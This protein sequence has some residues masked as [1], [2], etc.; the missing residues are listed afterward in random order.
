MTSGCSVKLIASSISEDTGIRLDTLQVRYWRP[1]HGEVMTHRVFSRNASSS[2]AIPAA[3]IWAREEVYVPRFRKNKPGMQPGAFLSESEQAEAAAIWIE[4]ARI[5]QD[6][7]GRLADKNGLN[8]HKQWVNRP[9]EWYSYIDVLITSTEWSNF[10]GLRIHPDAQDEIRELAT[11]MKRV[12]DAATPQVLKHGQWHL[13]YITAQDFEETARLV[14]SR[15]MPDA[16]CEVLAQLA[17]TRL[18]VSPRN[19]LLLAMSAARSCRISF[20]KHDGA[21]PTIENDAT[22]YLQLAGSEPLHASPL[23]HQGRPL[24]ATEDERLSGN[25]VGFAQF[26]K[27]LPNERL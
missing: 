14:K 3:S 21:R 9:T 27:F 20:A 24:H 10:D 6:Y 11:E 17:R 18:D 8:I 12:R 25:L 26:R 23:E 16:V 7:V 15:H 13:P 4:L 5:T 1:I 22:R 19:A 2:R